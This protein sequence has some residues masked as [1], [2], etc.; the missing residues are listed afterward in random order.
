MRELTLEE[1]ELISGGTHTESE[2]VVVGDGGGDDWGDWGDWGDYGDGGGDGG[3]GGGGGGD[4]PPTNEFP[5]ENSSVSSVAG[6]IAAKDANDGLS[7]TAQPEYGTTIA[8]SG[9][10]FYTGN[11]T[12]GQSY[13]QANPPS[14]SIAPPDGYGWADVVATIHSHPASGDS[15]VDL[16]NQAPSD[17][18]WSAADQA[19]AS[20]ASAS[21]LTMYIIDMNGVTRAF[22]YMS[23]TDRGATASNPSGTQ[24]SG[25]DGTVTDTT[26]GG[27][28]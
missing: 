8:S 12:A 17:G 2:I 13:D 26:S 15:A 6:E 4:P 21:S 14:T 10:N 16:R 27:C 3:G 9:G 1:L 11:V 5:C 19:V 18:D 20:G 22:D 25:S 23:P 28:G 7:G 24:T